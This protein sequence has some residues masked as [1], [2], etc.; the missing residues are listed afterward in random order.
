MLKLKNVS[1]K[2]ATGSNLT[3]L[4][5]IHCSFELGKIRF[6]S[7][8]I[9][10]RNLTQ[11]LILGRDFLLQHHITVCYAA[12]GKCVLD[13]Q[14]QEL[15]ASINI[16]G[17]PKLNMIYSMTI[18]GRTLPIVCICNNLDPNQSGYLYEIEPS[19]KIKEM[20]PNVHVIP[21][22]HNVDVHTTEHLP[23]VVINF[24]SDDIYLLKGETMGFMQIQSLEISEIMTE[25]STEPSSIIYEDDDKEVLNRQEGKFKKGNVE[26]K[27]ITSPAD[28]EVHRK[29]ELQD[30]DITD[31]QWQA[32]KDLCTES[33][34]TFFRS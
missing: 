14:Q 17:K 21:M 15:V 16:E 9:I 11:P 28:I 27:F 13:Y 25:T 31:E 6:H 18:P 23:L 5:M 32:I 19:D 33:I 26:K 1:V 20:Y 10:C 24:A 4:G 7:N 3:P 8:L 22:I 29:V 2:S 30:A 34:D 12:D